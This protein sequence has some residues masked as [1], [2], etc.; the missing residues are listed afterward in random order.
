MK[1]SKFKE[2]ESNLKLRVR[3]QNLCL[4]AAEFLSDGEKDHFPKFL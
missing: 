4:A 2:T 1:L 3:D